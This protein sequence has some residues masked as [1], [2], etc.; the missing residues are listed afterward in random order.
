MKKIIL[1]IF[2]LLAAMGCQQKS[3]YNQTL[4]LMAKYNVLGSGGGSTQVAVFS[5]TDWTVEFDHPVSWASIDRFSGHKTGYLNFDYEVNYGRA[6]RVNLVFKAGDQTRVLSM[7]QSQHISDADCL[8]ELG[9]TSSIAVSAE[10]ITQSIPFDTNLIYNLDEMYLTLTY[11]EG[12]EPQTPWITLLEVKENEV[13][14]EVA[15]NTAGAVRTANMR[16]SHTDAGSYNSTEG[17]TIHSNVI[18]VVQ[19]Q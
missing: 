5:N 13:R 14:I 9:G 10:G 11:P 1:Y 12:E 7:Y 19:T 2:V 4:G 8:M 16:I 3:E 17:D 15:R 18:T 6:R